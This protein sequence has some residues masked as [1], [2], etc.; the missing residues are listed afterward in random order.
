MNFIRAGTSN[1][2]AESWLIHKGNSTIVGES[3]VTG[4]DGKLV[5]KCLSAIMIM[6]K[7]SPLA[8]GDL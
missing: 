4:T 6:Q 5:A 3:I 1:L 2:T 7:T 8:Q